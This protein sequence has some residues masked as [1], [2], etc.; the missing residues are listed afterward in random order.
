[1]PGKFFPDYSYAETQ[2]DRICNLILATKQPFNPNNQMEKILIDAKM[3]FLGRPDYPTQIK[4]T[5]Q[6]AKGSRGKDKRSAI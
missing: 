2:I 1:M 4:L 5:V 6:G 3:E